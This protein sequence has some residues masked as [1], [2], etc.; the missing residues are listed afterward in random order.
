MGLK[1]IFFLGFFL[2]AS[3]ISSEVAA[4]QLA[5]TSN[6]VDK[7]KNEVDETNEITEEQYPG[8]GFGGFPGGGFGGYPGFGGFPGGGFGGYPGGGGGGYLGG[9][10]GE[11]CPFGCCGPSYFRPGSCTCCSYAGQ[12]LDVNSQN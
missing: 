9:I 8:G 2:A 4:R 6:S 3:L 1:T 10:G 11:G 12:A 5:G 7:P